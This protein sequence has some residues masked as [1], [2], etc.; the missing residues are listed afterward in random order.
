MHVLRWIGTLSFIATLAFG[1]DTATIAA[2]PPAQETQAPKGKF[3]GY[4]F[5]DYYYNIQ[6]RDTTRKDLNGVQLRRVYFTY[7]YAI[8][9]A[10]D[11]RFRLEADQTAL[12]SD[13]KIGVFVKDAYLK[14]KGIIHGSDLLFGVSPT[15]AYDASE[16]AWG[17]RSLEKT[18]MDLRGI[19]PSR[20][21]GVDLKGKL[22]GDGM[23]NYWLKVGNNSGNKPE[24][25]KFKR[26]YGQLHF[27]PSPQ[28]QLVA[29]GDFDTEPKVTDTFDGQ[30]KSNDRMVV[31]GFANF[32]EANK[33][34]VGL[35][36]FYRVSQNTFRPSAAGPLA[37]QNAFGATLFAW[38][39]VADDLRLVGRVD[40]YDPNSSVDQDGVS[41]VIAAL[42]YLPSADVH[43]MPNLYLQAYQAGGDNDVVGRLTFFYS[44][45]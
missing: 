35:E 9:P 34:S 5:G 10:F 11:A 39:A 44:F 14:W 24:T 37:N 18:I 29:S 15:P 22:T 31:S 38:G 36:A 41:L 40:F 42:D 16:E 4:M 19:V 1:Q 21:L 25:D 8:A 43:V 2:R 26:F 30:T 3:S 20:D 45:K 27:K 23:A 17:Y 28:V 6:Q 33:Y 7:D 13:G 32:R 12:T